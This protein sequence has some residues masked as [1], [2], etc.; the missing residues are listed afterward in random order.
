MGEPNCYVYFIKVTLKFSLLCSSRNYLVNSGVPQWV[1]VILKGLMFW[2]FFL[3]HNNSLYNSHT[4]YFFKKSAICYFTSVT[5][6][7][8]TFGQIRVYTSLTNYGS[9]DLVFKLEINCL[10]NLAVFSV[11]SITSLI[12]LFQMLVNQ[13]DCLKIFF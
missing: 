13:Q 12:L 8:S 1:T 7:K 9:R 11:Q 2:S 10:V 3:L 4:Y 6:V 5:H